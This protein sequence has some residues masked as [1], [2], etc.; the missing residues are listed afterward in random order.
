LKLTNHMSLTRRMGAG[1]AVLGLAAAFAGTPYRHKRG[2][3]DIDRTIRA[4]EDGSD[5]VSA[6]ELAGW[7]RAQKPGLRVIDV[8]P[9]EAFAV[10]AIP[11]AEN[12]PLDRLMQTDF[13]PHETVVLCSEGGAHAGQAW[14]LLQAL[15]VGNAWFIAGGLAD[16]HEQVLTPVLAADAG[17]TE[18]QA[19]QATAD[20]SRYF[21]GQPRIGEPG[22]AV[23]AV[24]AS[25]RRRRG[26]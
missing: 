15:G 14:V 17:E 6:L 8:R 24:E 22:C 25:S 23:S 19:F 26:C 10:F 1:A 13:A 20:L 21:G 7:I 16:W 9:P 12:I 4:I 5:H 2:R 18:K 11:T 3:I